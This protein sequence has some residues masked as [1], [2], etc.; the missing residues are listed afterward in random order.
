MLT[1][2]S[3]IIGNKAEIAIGQGDKSSLPEDI[4]VTIGTRPLIQLT[5]SLD[6]KQ[7]DWN[8][9]GAPVTV[10]I[11]YTPTAAEIANPESIVIWYIDGSGYA[12]SVPNGRYN[13][14]TVTFFTTHFSDYA[15]AH[16]H[17]T[18]SDLGGV[19]WAKKAIEVMASKGITSGT[20][21]ETFSPSESI[22]RADYMVLLINTL[23]LTADFTKNFDD[24]KPNTYY[25]HAVG[26]AKK[27]GIAAGSGNNRF[28]PTESISGQDMMVLAVRALEKFQGLKAADNS[29]SLDKFSDKRDIAEYAVN[30]LAALVNAGLIK[31]SGNVL[32]PRSSTT[33]YFSTISTTN[34]RKLRSSLIPRYQAF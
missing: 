22:T 20:G 21:N 10:Y 11:P 30:S 12:V 23:G 6:G 33:R 1:G 9:P 4:K 16:V 28:N 5:L 14:G 25:Y 8:N 26:I 19:E 17:K 24:V 7:T 2:V 32:N 34:T 3:G 31:G 13:T 27:L 29:T 15:V 18:F